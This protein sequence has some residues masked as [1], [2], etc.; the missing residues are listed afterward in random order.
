MLWR[1]RAASVPPSSCRKR[2]RSLT[3][4]SARSMP[5]MASLRL[6]QVPRARLP[7]A[8]DLRRRAGPRHEG[9]RSTVAGAG[10]RASA[11]PLLS[12]APD[13]QGRVPRANRARTWVKARPAQDGLRPARRIAHLLERVRVLD[14]C[15]II[16]KRVCTD[17]SVIP[18]VV[19]ATSAGGMVEAVKS[20][21][22]LGVPPFQEE[23]ELIGSH[24]GLHTQPPI[25][26]LGSSR[27][28]PRK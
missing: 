19:S 11:A 10:R 22:E 28:F 4:Y 20:R 12:P 7:L 2:L 18:V 25:L 14:L 13:Q 5:H 27:A 24:G 15:M 16:A 17:A 1:D 8:D 23:R 9:A 21:S 6:G 26:H 3:P